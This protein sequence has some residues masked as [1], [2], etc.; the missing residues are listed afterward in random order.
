MSGALTVV[1]IDGGPLTGAARRALSG[2]QVAVGAARHLAAADLLPQ[3]CERI[4]LGPLAPALERLRA[5]GQRP[6]VVL[7]SGDPGFFGIV[8]RL[9]SEGFDPDVLP[10]ASSVAVAFARLGRSWDQAVVVTAHG[11]DL[12]PALNACRAQPLV[13]VLTEPGAGGCELGA[14]LVGWSRRLVVLE[15]L[16]GPAERVWE[17]TAE[18]A[19][20]GDWGHPHVVV[21]IADSGPW[22]GVA[23]D[24]LRL[25]NQPAAAPAAGWALPETAY[26]HRDSMITKAE[27]RALV[28]ARLRPRLGRLIWDVGAGSGSVG[29][30]CAALGSA[31]IA[32]DSDQRACDLVHA[33]ASRHAVSAAVLVIRGSA[34]AVLRGLPDPDAAFVGGGGLD[35]LAAVADR[36]PARVVAALAALD[37]VGPAVDILRSNGFLVEGVQLSASRLT[38][39]PGGSLRLAATNPVVV[40][41]GER[42]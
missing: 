41:T 25:D 42:N 5:A 30:E 2:A 17:L 22:D 18:Q 12:R 37:R 28:V 14:G 8:R 27:V 10:A 13:A 9:R 26:S 7:A 33:N 19:A 29:V 3:A 39:L 1:G 6:V 20:A 34:P 32:L 24:P 11:R 15:N 23:D 36:R 35:A 38:D 21:S 4:T 31:V 40:L 16:G